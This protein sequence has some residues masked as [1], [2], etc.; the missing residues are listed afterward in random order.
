MLKRLIWALRVRQHECCG[1]KIA[2]FLEWEHQ[3]RLS[4]PKSYEVLAEQYVIPRRGAKIRSAGPYHPPPILEPSFKWIRGPL[5]AWLP[6]PGSISTPRRPRLRTLCHGLTSENEA[7][8]WPTALAH[9]FTG[10]VAVRQTDG[11]PVFKGSF[12]QQA[13][14]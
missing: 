9:R 14:A 7:A 13:R 4:V 3:L 5:V 8:F 6:S 1:Q 11:G 10:R 2:Y 12:A